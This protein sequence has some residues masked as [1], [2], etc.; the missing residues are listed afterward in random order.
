MTT[1]SWRLVTRAQLKRGYW[2]GS[3]HREYEV[4]AQ[5]PDGTVVVRN[6]ELAALERVNQ[7]EVRDG[8]D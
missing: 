1:E 8:P 5:R 4:I 6:P 3:H 7:S 2:E